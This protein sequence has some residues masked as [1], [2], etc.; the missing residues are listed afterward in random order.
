LLGIHTVDGGEAD[1]LEVVGALDACGRFADFLHG[2]QQQSNQD[3]NDGDHH[4]Q[5][6]QRE[7]TPVTKGVSK[8]HNNAPVREKMKE[9]TTIP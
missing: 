9:A 6:D 2:R 1:L 3:G 8:R 5:L 7:A 4:Q